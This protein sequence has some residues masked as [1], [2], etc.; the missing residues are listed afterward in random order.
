MSTNGKGD[1]PR[2]TN[3]RRY[4]DNYASIDWRTQRKDPPPDKESSRRDRPERAAK[5]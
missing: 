4:R 3:L 5:S 2:P 1:T